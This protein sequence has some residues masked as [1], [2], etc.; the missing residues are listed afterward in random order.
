MLDTKH[1]AALPLATASEAERKYHLQR[2]KGFC[3]TLAAKLQASWTLVR[4]QRVTRSK[5]NAQ[6]AAK[7]AKPGHFEIGTY[8][9][10]YSMVPRNK[11]RVRWMG[12]FQVTDTVNDA[13][14]KVRHLVTDKDSMAH[15]QRL[16]A[17]LRVLT[18]R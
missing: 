4:E 14:Y 9:L 2:V 3:A 15:A 8:V 11:L 12:P 13:V 7:R 16:R 6:Q 10:V 17:F 18:W 5:R 1:C